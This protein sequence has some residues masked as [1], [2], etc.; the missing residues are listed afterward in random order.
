[1]DRIVDRKLMP[2]EALERVA[3]ASHLAWRTLREDFPPPY[4]VSR[5][6][7]K[8]TVFDLN[9]ISALPRSPQ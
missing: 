9:T 1:V 5:Y 2:L 6:K 3:S 7:I 4:P 8:I